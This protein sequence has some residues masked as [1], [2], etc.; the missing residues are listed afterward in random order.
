[1]Y[2]PYAMQN[3]GGPPPVAPPPLAPWQQ[4]PW[5]QAPPVGMPPQQPMP[6]VYGAPPG[7][8]PGVDD[9]LR[10]IF[11]TGFPPDVRERELNNLLR[12][13]PGY[14]ASQ[15][16]WRNGQAQGFA[17]FADGGTARRASSTVGGLPFDDG[18][19]LRAEMARKN[20]YIHE[21]GAPAPG[22]PKRPRTDFG[23]PGGAPGG[24]RGGGP[25]GP[26]APPRGGLL[27][28]DNPPCSTLF[29][30]NLGQGT[31][32]DELRAVFGAQP[33][34]VQ[35]RYTLNPRGVTCFVE[36]DTVEDATAVHSSLQGK[37]LDSNDR[38]A[39]RIQFSKAPAGRKR[40]AGGNLTPGGSAGGGGGGG[41]AGGAAP[42]APTFLP[43]VQL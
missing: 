33:G 41:A 37:A 36:F 24:P 7:A 4:A 3:Y 38:G 5:Q 19:T 28:Q 32:E 43:I 21:G 6:V 31:T 29:I 8:H 9:E 15:M 12:F 30:G 27:P 18:V 10:T 35:L 14:Q 2:D 11:I 16:N 25:G 22:A 20:M 23:A 34:F 39:M 40:D 1:M 42:H 26:G 13:L 17:L